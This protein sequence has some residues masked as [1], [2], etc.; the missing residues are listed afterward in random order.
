MS[1]IVER[2]RAGCWGK[3]DTTIAAEMREAAAEL[4]R[5]TAEN[6]MFRKAADADGFHR[7]L[8]ARDVEIERL[9]GELVR[10]TSGPRDDEE[11]E[12]LRVALVVISKGEWPKDD[13]AQAFACR[14]LRALD[15][16]KR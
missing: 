3:H 1:N 9:R 5:L 8:A 12:R 10:A 4:E 7:V 14:T 13:C 15:G 2:L 6:E 16:E 11:I